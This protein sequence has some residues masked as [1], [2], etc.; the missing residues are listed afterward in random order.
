[1]KCH[2]TFISAFSQS[3]RGV[4]TRYRFTLIELLVVVSIIA[5]LMCLLLPAL[6]SARETSKRISCANSMKQMG[7]AMMGYSTDSNGWCCPMQEGATAYP[8]YV[9]SAFLDILGVKYNHHSGFANYWD[10]S[11]FCPSSMPGTKA[12]EFD[13]STYGYAYIPG[14][15]NIKF[16]YGMIS[17]YATY[18]G[19]GTDYGWNN[20]RAIRM[21]KVKSPSTSFLFMETPAGGGMTPNYSRNPADGW[22]V[23]GNYPE[24]NTYNFA[25][26]AYV[27]Y[28][29]GKGR[30]VNTTFLDG[31]VEGVSAG[32]LM[33]TNSASPCWRPYE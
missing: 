17:W 20:P 16:C 9:N 24:L 29:H 23:Y 6:N 1:M 7:V 18:I 31:H 28:R 4:L 22:L 21:S 30:M 5:I 2:Q 3:R 32:D 19:T 8:F 15:R 10:E 33:Q 26:P 11:F 14:L 13:Q 12:A 27:A 25:S